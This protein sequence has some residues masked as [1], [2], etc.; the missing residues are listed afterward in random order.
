MH[1]IIERWAVIKIVYKP[2][3]VLSFLL[4]VLFIYNLRC[5]KICLDSH[6]HELLSV[7]GI[8]IVISLL[9]YF[10]K[11]AS[12]QKR[13]VL[14]W[15]ENSTDFSYYNFIFCNNTITVYAERYANSIKIQLQLHCLY[16]FKIQTQ[17]FPSLL[18]ESYF[19]Y[20]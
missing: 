10:W 3:P 9:E 13:N 5:W 8:I 17:L 18:A 7:A 1:G 6:K 4:S 19:I 12:Q 15:L 20:L 2:C 16:L 14:L 11:V